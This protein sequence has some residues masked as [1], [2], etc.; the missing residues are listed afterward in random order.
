MQ[1]LYHKQML[2][3]A[4]VW[5]GPFTGIAAAAMQALYITHFCL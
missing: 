3:A 2:H 1:A 4:C 5:C